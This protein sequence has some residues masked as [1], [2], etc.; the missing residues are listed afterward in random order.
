MAEQ[1]TNVVSAAASTLK[2]QKAARP[3]MAAERRQVAVV[4]SAKKGSVIRLSDARRAD[5]DVIIVARVQ[6]RQCGW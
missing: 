5:I 3:A 6:K 4:D 2:R 1:V